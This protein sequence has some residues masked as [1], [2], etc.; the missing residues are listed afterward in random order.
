MM[1]STPVHSS[2]RIANCAGSSDGPILGTSS[3]IV[4]APLKIL[5]CDKMEIFARR[6]GLMHE[7]L[8]FPCKPACHA[9]QDISA[10]S[11][12]SP[13]NELDGSKN[14]LLD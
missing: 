13:V 7:V 9:W 12:M 10:Q 11:D 6:S 1:L 5:H 3:G 4:L 8:V 2:Q 14:M